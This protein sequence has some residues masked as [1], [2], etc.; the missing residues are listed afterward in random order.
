MFKIYMYKIATNYITLNLV[1][2]IKTYAN[3]FAMNIVGV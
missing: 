2:S 1:Q 3:I